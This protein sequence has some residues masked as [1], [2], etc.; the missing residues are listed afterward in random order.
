[1]RQLRITR[2]GGAETQ[3]EKVAVIGPDIKCRSSM[4][5]M[6]VGYRHRTTSMSLK[7]PTYALGGLA[8]LG[9]GKRFPRSMTFFSIFK[10]FVD[11]SIIL[12]E[13]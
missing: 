12:V 13:V 6:E 5:G 9:Q 8:C 2:G 4:S 3:G 10:G 7:H 1:M 11:S